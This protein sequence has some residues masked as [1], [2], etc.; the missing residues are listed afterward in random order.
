[1]TKDEAR[2]AAI[3][4]H[5]P[6]IVYLPLTA[7]IYNHLLDKF[8]G[9]ASWTKWGMDITDIRFLHPASPWEFYSDDADDGSYI[10]FK[11]AGIAVEFK[12]RFG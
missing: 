5:F 6:Y 4:K 12:L 2:R 7:D 10:F 11:E 3:G 1:M 8:G 9:P